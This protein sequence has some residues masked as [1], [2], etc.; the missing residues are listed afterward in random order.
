[1]SYHIHFF[2]FRPFRSAPYIYSSLS[3]SGF[4]E[5]ICVKSELSVFFGALLTNSITATTKYNKY[6]GI[7]TPA[8]ISPTNTAEIRNKIPETILALIVNDAIKAITNVIIATTAYTFTAVTKSVVIDIPELARNVET[9][10]SAAKVL[11]IG[12]SCGCCS[13]VS[14]WP[15]NAPRDT[16]PV[17]SIIIAFAIQANIFSIFLLNGFIKFSFG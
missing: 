6:T 7:R 9:P 13:A 15:E 3:I 1:M 11:N 16:N 10:C 14:N 4:S 2:K 12:S 17:I 5:V 8:V